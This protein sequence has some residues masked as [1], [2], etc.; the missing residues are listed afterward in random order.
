VLM[1]TAEAYF[2]VVLRASDGTSAN[3]WVGWSNYNIAGGG[4]FGITSTDGATCEG[5]LT[6][7][8]FDHHNPSYWNVN[9]DCARHYLYSLSADVADGDAS[10][11]A[12]MGLG[13]WSATSACTA[14]EGTGDALYLAVR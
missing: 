1:P 3:G 6:T 8:G 5:W 7:L 10:Y 2:P 9:C 11:H 13:G 4:D 14:A 12:N